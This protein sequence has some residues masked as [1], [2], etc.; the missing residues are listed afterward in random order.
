EKT[1]VAEPSFPG[2]LATPLNELS[3]Q[4]LPDGTGGNAAAA[5]PAAALTAQPTVILEGGTGSTT[6]PSRGS[7]PMNG[8]SSSVILS[9]GAGARASGL[10]GVRAISTGSVLAPPPYAHGHRS[11]LWKD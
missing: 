9:D 11:T 6:T 3:T 2:A 1:T 8:S 7:T 4:I 5:S 10:S